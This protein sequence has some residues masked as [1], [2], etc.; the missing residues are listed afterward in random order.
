[1]ERGEPIWQTRSTSPIS[2]PSSSEAVATSAFSSPRFSRCSESS[3]CSR[4][5]LP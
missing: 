3:R 5:R 4:A 1:M 2:M